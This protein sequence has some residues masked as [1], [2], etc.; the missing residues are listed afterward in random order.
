MHS[1]NKNRMLG[2]YWIKC[3]ISEDQHGHV[4]IYIS[5]GLADMHLFS[6]RFSFP[7]I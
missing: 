5:I 4:G 6:I 1:N 2:K 7:E 3:D